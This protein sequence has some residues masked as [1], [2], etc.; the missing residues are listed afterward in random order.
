MKFRLLNRQTLFQGFFKMDALE[1]EH[2]RFEGG[3]PIQIRREVMLRP[4]ASCV[5]LFDP[6][7][8][9]VVM[10]EQFRAPTIEGGNP[11]L[12]ELVAGLIDKE[13]ETPDEV[14]YRE[15][16]EEAGLEILR[17]QKITEYWSSPGASNE[18]VHIYVGQVDASNAG[19]IHGLEDEGEDIRVVVM[20]VDEALKLN[21]QGEVNN[22]AAI[23]ALQWFD[24]NHQKLRQ[25]WTEG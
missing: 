6:V 22:A 15:S 17:L 10:I 9:E 3:E 7:R 20:P 1:V 8:D 24:L 16:V 18:Y 19:G 25:N 11:W 23:I 4:Q 5:L 14:A 13:H 21:R 12:L 2:D